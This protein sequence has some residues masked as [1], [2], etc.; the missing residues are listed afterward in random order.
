VLSGSY[1]RC[2]EVQGS[3]FMTPGYRDS[4][5][6]CFD[7]ERVQQSDMFSW[8]LEIVKGTVGH[9]AFI[10]RFCSAM[11]VWAHIR[12]TSHSTKIQRSGS[13]SVRSFDILYKHYICAG[14][15]LTRLLDGCRCHFSSS[16]P[17]RVDVVEMHPYLY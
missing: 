12:H 5:S 11:A 13:T 16:V 14:L 10:V 3:G 8:I 2:H 17:Q 7:K 4:L 15:E 6:V 1:I 9:W